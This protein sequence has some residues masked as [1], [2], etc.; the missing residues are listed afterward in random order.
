MP[1]Q[2][3]KNIL[4]YAKLYEVVCGQI[5]TLDEISSRERSG[6]R[7]WE[8]ILLCK[9]HGLWN[10]RPDWMKQ[11]WHHFLKFGDFGQQVSSSSCSLHP[12]IFY[13]YHTAAASNCI[14][15][16]CLVAQAWEILA[17]RPPPYYAFLFPCTTTQVVLKSWS[18]PQCA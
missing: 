17:S 3:C 10:R 13:C 6:A 9:P 8:N 4:G 11:A 2:Y 14:I 7:C 18:L 1:L 16:Y 12:N 15:Y 5:E